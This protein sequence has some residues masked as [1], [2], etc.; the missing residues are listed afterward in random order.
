MKYKE[1]EILESKYN[2]AQYRESLFIAQQQEPLSSI[3]AVKH[4]G[5]PAFFDVAMN[6]E[7]AVASARKYII[8]V[9]KAESYLRTEMM[10][11]YQNALKAPT[12]IIQ[13]RHRNAGIDDHILE[14][15]IKAS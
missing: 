13:D 3:L 10:V 6:H 15:G 11:D 7:K 9:N 2:E 1:R 14:R 5:N 4:H 12:I 8:R